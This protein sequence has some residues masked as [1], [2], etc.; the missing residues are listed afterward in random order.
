MTG[1]AAMT[2]PAQHIPAHT[3][4]G[5]ADGQFGFRAEG[6]PPTVAHGVWTPHQTV[7]HLCRSRQRPQ[8]MIAVVADMHVTGTDRTGALLDIKI[9]PFED[10]PCG[11]TIRHDDSTRVLKLVDGSRRMP[12]ITYSTL[13]SA[14]WIRGEGDI[15]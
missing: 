3:P 4:A 9:D 5:H 12:T 8:M 13:L 6:L 7:D 11:P 1:K 15:R 14:K 2:K 10:G